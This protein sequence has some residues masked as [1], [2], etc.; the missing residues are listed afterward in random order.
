M[1][2]HKNYEIL[3]L[4]GYGLAKFDMEFVRCLGFQTKMA[5][6][7]LMVQR[8]IADTVGVVKNRQD[9][10]D[11][12]FENRRQGWWQKGDVYIHRKHLIDSLFGSLD[13][14]D[15]SNIVRLYLR[16][17][18][19][20]SV[21]MD[22]RGK[23]VGPLVKTKFKQLQITGQ[24]AELF[25]MSNFGRCDSFR[26]GVLED[27]RL[28]GDGY[29]FQVAVRRQFFL[30]EIKGLRARHGS[31]RMTEKEYKR[32][33]EYEDKYALVVVT[34][35]GETPNMSVV[36]NPVERINF[37]RRA[38]SPKQVNYHSAALRWR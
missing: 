11:P 19:G 34:N 27:A 3:N 32:A 15:F 12:F 38:S 31:V 36:F 4:I 20:I 29:D 14:A 22:E 13:A 23:A 21:A 8:G 35:L 5:F 10:F 16:E 17:N 25:F 30:A 2:K 18:F 1:T 24:E 9:L 7:R 28:F 37:T 26:D 6:Y 33:Q